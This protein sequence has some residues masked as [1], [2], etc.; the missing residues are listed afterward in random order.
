MPPDSS[1]TRS[2]E[3]RRPGLAVFTLGVLMLLTTFGLAIAAYWS[4][5]GSGADA[6]YLPIAAQF[7]FLIVLAYTGSLVA[8]KGIELYSAG[9]PPDPPHA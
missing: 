8:S 2:A 5:R 7:A 3:P 1:V 9:Q 6:S 4:A